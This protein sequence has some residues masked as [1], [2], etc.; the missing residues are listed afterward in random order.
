[1]KDI[2]RGELE[3]RLENSCR[4]GIE[5]TNII[6]GNVHERLRS[7]NDSHNQPWA[8]WV[9]PLSQTESV[10]C[11]QN[12]ITPEAHEPGLEWH[13]N[14]QKTWKIVVPSERPAFFIGNAE[15]NGAPEYR[16][17]R[18]IS[19]AIGYIACLTTTT[20]YPIN[21]SMQ[22]TLVHGTIRTC[23]RSSTD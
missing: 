19:D 18:T 21:W 12:T 15:T 7:E 5:V 6:P 10:D 4:F 23:A 22:S 13:C 2:A 8:N 9:W 11:R 20:R 17:L 14:C 3:P 1:M 16:T